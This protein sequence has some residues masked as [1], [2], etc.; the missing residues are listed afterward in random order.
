MTLICAFSPY[1]FGKLPTG[2]A[3]PA[4]LAFGLIVLIAGRS[5]WHIYNSLEALF[6]QGCAMQ[7]MGA[8]KVCWQHGSDT[9]PAR[10][11]W[12]GFRVFNP[13]ERVS[14][15]GC[16]RLAGFSWDRL[17]ALPTTFYTGRC[18]LFVGF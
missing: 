9:A 17:L 12:N 10:F 11:A 13:H 18:F 15:A 3:I 7:Y 8:R 5:V 14:Q 1:P 2:Y 6:W 16:Q 4:C